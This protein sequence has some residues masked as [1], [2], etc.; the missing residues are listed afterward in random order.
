M[1]IKVIMLSFYCRIGAPASIALPYGTFE[2]CLASKENSAVA[3]KIKTLQAELTASSSVS[4]VP[5]ALSTLRHVISSELKAPK[6]F[7]DDVAAAAAV[8]GLV[9]KGFWTP[10]GAEWSS[11]WQAICTVWAS[12]W[13]DRAWLS[14][15]AQGIAEDSLYMAVLLQQ[16]I[17]ADYAFVLHTANP[18]T[19]GYIVCVHGLLS[20]VVAY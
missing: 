2:R 16:V 17:P 11:S 18:I 9:P 6:G 15:R 19:V 13:N 14:R 5:A 8:A 12:K 1:L 3:S 4:G 20:F 10:D 7:F